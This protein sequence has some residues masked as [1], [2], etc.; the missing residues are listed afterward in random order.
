MLEKSTDI[1]TLNPYVTLKS[2][3]FFMAYNVH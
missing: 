2:F 1:D 3:P